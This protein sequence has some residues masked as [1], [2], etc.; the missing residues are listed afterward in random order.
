MQSID[1]EFQSHHVMYKRH[2]AVYLKKGNWQLCQN[3]QVTLRKVKDVRVIARN[4]QEFSFP[5]YQRHRQEQQASPLSISITECLT[6]ITD[7]TTIMVS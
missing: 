4:K 6:T 1:F 2:V 7:T 5:H 3:V